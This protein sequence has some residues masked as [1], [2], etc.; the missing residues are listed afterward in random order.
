MIHIKKY[1]DVIEKC[2]GLLNTIEEGFEYIQNQIKE[3]RYENAFIVLQDIAEGISSIE[4]AIMPMEDKLPNN[5]VGERTIEVKENIHK[6]MNSY[7][8]EKQSQLEEQIKQEIYPAFIGWK[9][10][11]ERILRPYLLA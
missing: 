3:L 4:N 7:K 10:E 2:L 5:N 1:Y 11:V 8:Q 6:A 9:E